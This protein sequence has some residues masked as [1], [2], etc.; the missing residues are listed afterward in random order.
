MPFRP[1]GLMVLLSCEYFNGTVCTEPVATGRL[2][3]VSE[4]EVTLRAT[5]LLDVLSISLQLRV[6]NTVSGHGT[7]PKVGNIRSTTVRSFYSRDYGILEFPW[8]SPSGSVPSP[9]SVRGV[10]CMCEVINQ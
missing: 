6:K 4:K 8:D 10:V 5:I 7:Q 3:S 1:N 2:N 9:C